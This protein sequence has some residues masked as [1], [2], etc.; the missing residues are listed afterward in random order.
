MGFIVPIVNR[1]YDELKSQLQ[2]KVQEEKWQKRLVLVIVSTAL[3]LDNMLYMVIVPIIPDYLR[4]IGAY[5]ITYSYE[6]VNE[7]ISTGANATSRL[8]RVKE[9]Q[10]EDQSL[11]NLFASKAIVQLLVNPFSGMLIDKI[12]YE[13]PMII[14][15]IVMFSSTAIFALGQSYGVLFFA[16]SLQGLGSAFADTSGLAMIANRFPE[17]NERSRSMGIALAFIS[18]GSLVAPPFGGTL[19]EFAGKPVPFLVLSFVCLLDGFMVFMLIHPKTARTEM[20]ERVKGPNAFRLLLDPYIAICAGAL[21][22][23]N[24]SLAFLE[25]TIAKW[26]TETMPTVTE[27]Q[28]G[29]VWLPPFVP[30]IL[31]VYSAVR[32]MKRYPRLPWFIAAVGLVLEG[33]S[34][35][36]VP[37]TT[38]YTGVIIPLAILCYGIALVDT[39]LLPLLGFLVDTRH[40]AVYGSIYAIVDI[41]YSLA[42]AIGP[43][44]AGSIVANLGFF[45]LNLIICLSN[46]LYAPALSFIKT[47]YAY[48]T[49]DNEDAPISFKDDGMLK[50]NAYGSLT[51]EPGYSYSYDNIG[52][53]REMYMNQF[54]PFANL[55]KQGGKTTGSTFPMD[56]LMNYSSSRVAEGGN[57]EAVDMYASG[58][59]WSYT[60]ENSF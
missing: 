57:Q 8:R 6:Q 47:V 40:A 60:A 29:L 26:M 24:I 52:D 3:L 22:T 45:T 18:F 44:V 46:V 48:K 32:L 34:C 12:G 13:I 39:A 20:G 23:A 43:I 41:S 36:I 28:I 5:T 15:L 21:V 51:D 35:F 50:S 30:H 49:F 54:D 25:P 16:R 37:F 27:W 58:E 55:P 33:V 53:Q 56:G 2:R 4:R 10:S 1:D 17:E 19:Y 11:G 9:Y 59:P 42:Y 38:N 14:G 31:G 7:T